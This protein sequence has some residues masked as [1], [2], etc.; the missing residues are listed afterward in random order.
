[1]EPTIFDFQVCVPVEKPV[2]ASGRV[3]PGRIEARRVARTVYHGGYEGLGA[4]WAEL[5]SWIESQ[6][7]KP[8]A[9]LWEVYTAGP[10]S[11]PDPA[12]WPTELNQPLLDQAPGRV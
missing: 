3:Q 7:L 8:A 1:M 4:A 10:E 12:S 2:S 9:D 11:G 6:G 5:H